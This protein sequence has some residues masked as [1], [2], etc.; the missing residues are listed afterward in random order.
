MAQGRANESTV[1]GHLGHARG[2]VMPILVL[3]VR[4]P[5]CEE[6]LSTGKGTGGQHLG[7]QWVGLEL[8]EVG[9]GKD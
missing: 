9:L 7:A 5:R 4:N 8:L 1:N 2:E 3:I 6:L